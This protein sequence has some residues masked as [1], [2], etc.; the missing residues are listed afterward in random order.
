MNL[1]GGFNTSCQ[2][3][4]IAFNILQTSASSLYANRISVVA[5][6]CSTEIAEKERVPYAT[7]GGDLSLERLILAGD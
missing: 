1:K 7:K 6:F 2:S 4:S 5:Q 3:E